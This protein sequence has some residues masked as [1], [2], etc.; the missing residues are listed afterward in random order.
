MKCKLC[1]EETHMDNDDICD[2]CFK[3]IDCCGLEKL[4]PDYDQDSYTW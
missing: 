1:G 4:E 3:N 2:D